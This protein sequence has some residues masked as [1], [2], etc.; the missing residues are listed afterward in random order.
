[1]IIEFNELTFEGL[2]VNKYEDFPW[3]S[4][5]ER[6]E[7][8]RNLL[9]GRVN[10]NREKYKNL[11]EKETKEEIHLDLSKSY[12]SGFFGLALLGLG[13]IMAM[14]LMLTAVLVLIG[15]AG[16][17]ILAKEVFKRRARVGYMGLKMTPQLIDLVF[18]SDIKL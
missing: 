15:I 10:Y 16:V 18:D 14:K 2:R 5:K 12:V 4:K 3:N 11:L 9:D 17:C 1:M 8:L 6:K 7:F 13:V